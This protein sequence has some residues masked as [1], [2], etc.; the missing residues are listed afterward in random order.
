MDRLAS[1]KGF[2]ALSTASQKDDQVARLEVAFP[3]G[4]VGSISTFW[5]LNVEKG[6][7]MLNWPLITMASFMIELLNAGGVY[8]FSCL[9]NWVHTRGIFAYSHFLFCVRS[10]VRSKAQY[11]VLTTSAKK[12]FQ[13]FNLNSKFQNNMWGGDN[14][15]KGAMIFVCLDEC[16]RCSVHYKCPSPHFRKYRSS[17]DHVPS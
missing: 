10:L 9:V 7:S 3:G 13:I 12:Q 2:K 5:L 17:L 11:S 14:A 15:C 1:L 8:L 16:L 6:L 4:K